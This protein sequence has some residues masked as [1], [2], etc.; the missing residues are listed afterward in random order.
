MRTSISSGRTIGRTSLALL[1][2]AAVMFGASWA[3]RARAANSQQLN[4]D[5]T[6]EHRDQA[7]EDSFPASDAPASHN[8][9]IPSNAH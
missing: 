1:F 4:H 6:D 9:E 7:L 8:Y 5:A 2:G 3:R